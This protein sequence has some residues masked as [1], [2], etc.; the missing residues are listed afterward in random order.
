MRLYGRDGAVR[1]VHSFSV[2][3]RNGPSPVVIVS[4]HAGS[5][6]SALLD[7]LEACLDQRVSY[8]RVNC[9]KR[10][11][12]RI[13]EV[14]SLLVHDLN[15]HCAAYGRIPFPR[16]IVGC[17]AM[18]ADGIDHNDPA[19]AREQI[20]NLL[21]KHRKI[22]ELKKAITTILQA[23]VAA[24]EPDV[25]VSPEV[26]EL[27][28]GGLISWTPVRRVVLGEGPNWYSHQDRGLRRD[29]RDVLAELNR[30]AKGLT[31]DHGTEIDDLLLAAFLADLRAHFATR[32]GRR[33]PYNCVILLDDA[34][35]PSGTN[36]LEALKAAFHAHADHGDAIGPITVVAT[37]RGPLIEPYVAPGEVLPT[38][39]EASVGD[40]RGRGG[41]CYLVRL[42]DLALDQVYAMVKDKELREGNAAD[43]AVTVHRF[44]R[45]HAGTTAELLAAISERPADPAEPREVLE[46][47]RG[48]AP[49]ETVWARL[50]KL[51]L[52]DTPDPVRENLTTCAAAR[53]LG[54]AGR[55]VGQGGL[56][57]AEH[58]QVLTDAR[59][60]LPG[61]TA[62]A[63][64]MLPVLRRLLLT[65]L[66][67]RPADAA[68]GWTAVHDLLRRHAGETGD[69]TGELYHSL[70]LGE[71]E[72]VVERLTALLRDLGADA[73]LG[74][75]DQVAEAPHRQGFEKA[76]VDHANALARRRD[77][78]D[79]L[80]GAVAVLLAG[81][82]VANEPLAGGSRSHLTTFV[83][84][85]LEKVAMES[86][87]TATLLA[88]ARDH[89]LKAIDEGRPRDGAKPTIENPWPPPPPG[90]TWLKVLAAVCAVLLVLVGIPVVRSLSS[91]ASGVSRV[92]VQVGGQTRTECVGV[93]DGY[94]FEDRFR[95]IIE[96]LAEENRFAT[97]GGEGS[98]VT[99]AFAGALTNPDARVIHQLEGAIAGQHRSNR[100][101]LVGDR[102]RIRMVL[103]NMGSTESHWRQIADELVAMADGP[104]RLV[105]VVGLGLSQD[106]TKLAAE[107]LRQ[108]GLPMV[109]DILTA[110]EVDKT[111]ANGLARVNP[112][113]E[114][115][116]RALSRYVREK[117]RLRRAMMVSY[118]KENDLYTK[119]LAG[120]LGRN[121]AELWERGGRINN[122]FGEDPGNEFRVIVGN[123]CSANAPDTI[124]YAGRG[125]DLPT[126]L[127]YLAN[128][129]CHPERITVLTGSDSVRILLDQPENRQAVAALTSSHNPISLLYVPLAEPSVLRDESK[130]P[131]AP[132]FLRFE[133][134][135]R[136]LGFDPD[137]LSTGWAVMAHDAVLTAAHAIRRATHS[138]QLPAPAAVRNQLYLI[139]ADANSVPGAS[140]QITIDPQTGNRVRPLLPV[141]RM[142]PG[143][144]PEIL[145]LRP[146]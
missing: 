14:L 140:G 16:F 23:A 79:P 77:H 66:A 121:M 106:E 26:I 117:S 146:R 99:V 11:D 118:S 96:A 129:H 109:A 25:Q 65:R 49:A 101:T 102:P 71:L 64:R 47:K 67:D 56:I 103:A 3:D 8:S 100:E 72:E 15:K 136:G 124:L 84:H 143:R 63:P 10:P 41:W 50:L 126:F 29:Y 138:G 142:R 130:N 137:D 92:E 104:E 61:A 91:C 53:D 86:S 51:L 68:D 20:H 89:R 62:G 17:I 40:Y 73:W 132:Q 37:S 19:R 33:I 123:L 108:A 21:E 59:I 141:L 85:A 135:F 46:R 83:R 139:T 39:D 110:A 48:R 60:W 44:T 144:E 82:W 128:R 54:E 107:R 35:E 75:V 27:L 4:G 57:D 31:D 13:P 115:E 111:A 90:R 34:D 22:P 52:G 78:D 1:L 105:A 122:P 112:T 42:P 120:S 30:H 113:T 98:Y 36:L 88:A 125:R 74:L 131:E 28:L 55:L 76:P 45:G 18:N 12:W 9:G 2:R 58:A 97:E 24:V 134:S 81:L 87:D 43:I 5:G 114:D 32:R 127:G 70:A 69:R 6:K 95:H 93:T 38:T 7:Y 116:M 80:T 133:N 94:A 119:S 145:E